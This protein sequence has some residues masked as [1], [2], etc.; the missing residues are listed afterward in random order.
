M[1]RHFTRG[2]HQVGRPAKKGPKLPKLKQVLVDPK[3]SWHPLT[4]ANWSG[5]GPGQVEIC[6]DPAVWYHNGMPAVP[7]RWV[8]IRDPKGKFKT[9]ALLCTDQSATPDQI[10]TWFVRRWQ[11][12][13]TFQEVR[14]HLGVES[15][16]QWAQK[17]I[18]RTMPILTG[19]FSWVTLLAHQSQRTGHLP[20]R[21]T[22]RYVKS[23]PTIADAIAVVCSQIWAHWGFCMSTSEGDMQ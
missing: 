11:V 22:A 12:E 19:L 16:R 3:T 13:V 5:H 14:T 1:N 8:L 18:A 10:L 20:I 4:E 15:Q 2:P 9:R 17:A 7:I 6:T 23:Q 21:R